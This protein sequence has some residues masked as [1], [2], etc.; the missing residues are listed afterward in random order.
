VSNGNTWQAPS[1]STGFPASI[2]S[3]GNSIA[4]AA[5]AF[6]QSQDRPYCP[7]SQAGART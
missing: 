4:M 3:V 2:F 1:T 5:P 7:E 6:A